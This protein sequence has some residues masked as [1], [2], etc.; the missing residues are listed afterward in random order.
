MKLIIPTVII[1]L[2]STLGSACSSYEFCRC[3]NADTSVNIPATEKSCKNLGGSMVTTNFGR[4]CSG[5]VANA[6]IGGV[7]PV[8]L[9]NCRFRVQC[10]ANGAP[11]DSNCYAKA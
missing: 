9:N 3:H 10:N 11:L 5:Y 8:F 4:Y 6:G 1:T 2:L 7:Q